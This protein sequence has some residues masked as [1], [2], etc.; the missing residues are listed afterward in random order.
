MLQKRTAGLENP[1]ST[2]DAAMR[3]SLLIFEAHMLFLAWYRILGKQALPQIFKMQMKCII[4]FS[5]LDYTLK[6][7][8]KGKKKKKKCFICGDL[9]L[10]NGIGMI[11]AACI[12]LEAQKDVTYKS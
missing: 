3:F 1:A 7:D 6:H 10:E 4:T 2:R 12:R 5:A 8:V 9:C 11:Y